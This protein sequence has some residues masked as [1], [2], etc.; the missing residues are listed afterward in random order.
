MPESKPEQNNN[1]VTLRGDFTADPVLPTN[2]RVH[3]STFSRLWFY[4]V[5]KVELGLES[6]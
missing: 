5:L 2:I 3:Y 4:V 1:Y 6:L